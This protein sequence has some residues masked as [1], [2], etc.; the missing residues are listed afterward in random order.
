MRHVQVFYLHTVIN[1]KSLMQYDCTQVALV[2]LILSYYFL[3]A[4]LM[5]HWK[6]KNESF[7]IAYI[8]FLFVFFDF[9]TLH[10][11]TVKSIEQVLNNNTSAD[12]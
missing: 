7:P 4:F 10:F 2:I 9:F 6:S 8:S 12:L 3:S 1:M 11:Y 5:W